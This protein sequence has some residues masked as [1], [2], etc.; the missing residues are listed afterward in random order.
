[1]CGS[2]RREQHALLCALVLLSC[3]CSLAPPAGSCPAQKNRRPAV[4]LRER[5]KANSKQTLESSVFV[6]LQQQLLSLRQALVCRFR[7]HARAVGG[8]AAA[9]SRRALSLWAA[10]AEATTLLHTRARTHTRTHTHTQT[11]GQPQQL[12]AAVCNVIFHLYSGP[13]RAHARSRTAFCTHT[14]IF[15]H[16][17]RQPLSAVIA[18]YAHTVCAVCVRSAPVCGATRGAASTAAVSRA[19]FDAECLSLLGHSCAPLLPSAPSSPAAPA[20]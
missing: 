3:A 1:M 15:G 14:H 19:T 7:A 9:S 16:L 13:D 11:Q 6:A 4:A 8:G 12:A 5:D 20:N 2:D 17:S 10:A 18:H